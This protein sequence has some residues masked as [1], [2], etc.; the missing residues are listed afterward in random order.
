[1]YLMHVV[2]LARTYRFVPEFPP[3]P[4]VELPNH[5]KPS[6]YQKLRVNRPSFDHQPM[7]R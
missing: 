2:G 4:E 1:M 3:L 5:L 6:A 7:K